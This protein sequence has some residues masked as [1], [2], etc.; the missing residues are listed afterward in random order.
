[1]SRGRP[2]VN[3]DPWRAD[4]ERWVEQRIPYTGIRAKLDR[5]GVAIG[6]TAFKDKLRL[7]GI[8]SVKFTTQAAEAQP[9]FVAALT[10]LFHTTTLSDIDISTY[11]N[12]NHFKTSP[13]QVKEYRL[14]EQLR[15]RHLKNGDQEEAWK[16]TQ[17]LCWSSIHNGPARDWGRTYLHSWLRVQHHFHASMVHVQAALKKINNVRGLDRRP[18]FKRQKKEEAIFLGPD[19][20]WSVDGHEK[21]GKNFGIEIYGAIDAHSRRLIWLYVGVS[22]RTQVAVAKQ[23]ARVVREYNW[24]PRYIRSDRGVETPIMADLHCSLSRANKVA[25]GMTEA[26]ANQLP[27]G[28]CYLYGKSTANQRIESVWWQLIRSCTGR[29]RQL[30]A[31]IKRSGLHKLDCPSDQVVFLFVFM[32]LL[33]DEVNAWLLVHNARRIRKD[34][35]RPNHLAGV[36]TKSMVSSQW[37]KCGRN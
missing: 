18:G 3:L 34:S 29:W 14:K 8:Q 32:P 23:Y 15:R 19:F 12:A 6:K 35:K 10:E 21:L 28:K 24:V 2:S 30:F 20:C 16:I 7:W 36:P 11:M 4:I 13:Y 17:D 1:M 5:R 27:L 26:D 33:R 31:H 22:A 25:E 9:D 37:A